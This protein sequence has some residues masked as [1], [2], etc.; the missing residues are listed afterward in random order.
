MGAQMAPVTQHEKQPHDRDDVFDRQYMVKKE[1]Y[2]Q[3]GAPPDEAGR[4]AS[5]QLKTPA[6]EPGGA[7]SDRE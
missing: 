6:G 4:E 5:E 3:A 2:E 1:S 7:H